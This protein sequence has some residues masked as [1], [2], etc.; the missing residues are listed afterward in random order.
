MFDRAGTLLRGGRSVVLD[1]TFYLERLRRQG[2]VVGR[3][4]GVPV[5]V[6]E[7]TAPLGVASSDASIAVAISE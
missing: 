5:F 7:V 6:V 1:A 2:A 4:A 3:R